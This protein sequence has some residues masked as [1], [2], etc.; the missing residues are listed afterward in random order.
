MPSTPEALPL[1]IPAICTQ[2]K[3]NWML[4]LPPVGWNKELWGLV[5]LVEAI[6]RT[7]GS[8]WAKQPTWSHW[9]WCQVLLAGMCYYVHWIC[10]VLRWPRSETPTWHLPLLHLHQHIYNHVTGVSS[11]NHGSVYIS[12]FKPNTAADVFFNCNTHDSSRDSA[13]DKTFDLH[14]VLYICFSFFCKYF[15]SPVHLFTQ[16]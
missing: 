14:P 10:L 7:S 16:M 2:K 3:K 8:I 1:A 5:Y 15:L 12:P 9:C 4:E 13:P 6:D 11:M